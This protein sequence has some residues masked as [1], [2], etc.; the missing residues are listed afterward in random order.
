M[1]QS[2]LRLSALTDERLPVLPTM[3]GPDATEMLDA[4]IEASGGR[5]T[6]ANPAQVTW[7]PGRSLVVRY[8]ARVAWHN[9]EKAMP[10]VLVASTGEE[11]PSGATVVENEEGRV[12]VWRLGDDPGL[13]GLAVVTERE[14]TRSLLDEL[15]APPGPVKCRLRS[16]RPTRRAVAELQV[17]KLRLFAKVVAPGEVAA[18][19]SRHQ[20]LAKHLPVPRSHGWSEEYGIVMLKEMTG[21]TLR[22]CLVEKSLPLPNP[23]E[24]AGLLDRIPDPGDSVRLTSSLQNVHEYVK[25]LRHILPKLDAR[26]DHL[27][28]QLSDID[29]SGPVVPIHGDFYEAQMLVSQGQVTGLL[30]VDTVGLGYRKTTGRRSSVI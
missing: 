25:L 24:F 30:D 23:Q 20:L 15:N 3:L 28:E 13:P 22:E 8:E 9:R 18:L 12:V 17:G 19:Q 16:Y 1:R 6:A 27:V 21:A 4:A 26:L 10:E 7:R 2:R 11:L 14:R 29:D 5:V